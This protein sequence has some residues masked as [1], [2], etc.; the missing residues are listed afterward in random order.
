MVEREGEVA[1]V[2]VRGVKDEG[3]KFFL[4]HDCLLIEGYKCHYAKIML[5]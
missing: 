3:F 4:L 1:R 2:S 5:K